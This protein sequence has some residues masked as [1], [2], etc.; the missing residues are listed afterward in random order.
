MGCLW[1]SSAMEFWVCV[2]VKLEF[3]VGLASPIQVLVSWSWERGV[4]EPQSMAMESGGLK[5]WVGRE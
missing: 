1:D 5:D 4:E 3:E 2:R